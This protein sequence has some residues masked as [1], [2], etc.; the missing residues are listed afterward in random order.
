MRT[1]GQ[2]H[3]ENTKVAAARRRPSTRA[4]ACSKKLIAPSYS[5]GFVIFQLPI[6]ANVRKLRFDMKRSDFENSRPER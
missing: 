4:A 1:Q 2:R 6:E 3:E 5:I